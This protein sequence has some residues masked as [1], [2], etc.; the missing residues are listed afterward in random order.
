MGD[1]RGV[2]RNGFGRRAT[3]VARQQKLKDI[4]QPVLDAFRAQPCDMCGCVDAP[5]DAHHADPK[6]KKFGVDG[7]QAWCRKPD[8]FKAEVEK[9]VPLCP[10]CHRGWHRDYGMNTVYVELTDADSPQLEMFTICS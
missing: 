1:R 10:K 2:G 8:D 6:Q 3:E 9:C 5:C 4:N 7:G